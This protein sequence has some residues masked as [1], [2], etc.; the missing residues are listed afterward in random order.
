MPTYEIA[1]IVTE[2][3]DEFPCEKVKS[4]ANYVVV[5]TGNQL[6]AVVIK[7][8]DARDPVDAVSKGETKLRA[9][10]GLL[11]LNLSRL[12]E[13]RGG[14]SVTETTSGARRHIGAVS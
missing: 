12:V 11:Y 1:F 7:G 4:S 13:F 3:D 9:V 6:S 2:D 10:M 5:C 8:I 14:H